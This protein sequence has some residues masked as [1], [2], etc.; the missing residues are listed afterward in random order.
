MKIFIRA[1][2]RGGKKVVTTSSSLAVLPPITA[3]IKSTMR[4][5]ARTPKEPTAAVSLLRLCY[6]ANLAI[7]ATTK[8][9]QNIMC[10][11]KQ[12]VP[13]GWIQTAISSSSQHLQTATADSAKAAL[14]LRT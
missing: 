13:A 2:Y 7:P 4:K 6:A 14:T 8:I 11:K 5:S 3:T 10:Q 12:H 9:I 1:A